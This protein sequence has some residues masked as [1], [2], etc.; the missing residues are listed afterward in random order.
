VNDRNKI[1]SGMNCRLRQTPNGTTISAKDGRRW[2]HPWEV[3]CQWE[4]KPGPSDQSEWHARIEP[5]FVNGRDVWIDMP[6]AFIKEEEE[7]GQDFG[8]NPLT[9]EPYFSADIFKKNKTTKITEIPAMPVALTSDPSPY[10]TISAWNNPLAS[11]GVKITGDGEVVTESGTGYPDIFKTFGVRPPDGED[12]DPERTREIRSAEIVLIQPRVASSVSIAPASYITDTHFETLQTTFSNAY[13]N[14]QKGMAR[15][16]SKS[17]YSP[18]AQRSQQALWG[19][20]LEGGDS[21]ED[22]LLVATVFMV[23][24]PD[25]DPTKEPDGSWTPYVRHNVFWNLNHATPNQPG[26]FKASD[27]IFSGIRSILGVLGGGTMSGIA[28][29]LLAM[30]SDMISEIEQYFAQSKNDGQFWNT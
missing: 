8:I 23:S 3:S 22:T 29:G 11:G 6:A 28:A 5:G 10:L 19:M 17:R 21:Q 30:Q 20:L 12:Q 24:P 2:R 14:S 16:V 15:L 27:D 25:Q 4:A 26:T 7:N 18:P 13:Y 1:W 9:G